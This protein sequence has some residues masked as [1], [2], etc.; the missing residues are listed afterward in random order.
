MVFTANLTQRDAKVNCCIKM[1]DMSEKEKNQLHH[2]RNQK[3]KMQISNDDG[4][5]RDLSLSNFVVVDEN[6]K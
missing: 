6:R 3:N 2:I 1:F 5:A 4:R